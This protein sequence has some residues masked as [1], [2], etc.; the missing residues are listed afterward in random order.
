M[1]VAVALEHRFSRTPDGAVWTESFFARTFWERYL[2]VFDGVRIVARVKDVDRREDGWKRVDGNGVSIVPIPYYVGPVAYLRNRR[3]VREA[4]RRAV[5]PED[6]VILSRQL[7]N[8]QLRGIGAAPHPAI[9]SPSRLWPTPTASSLRAPSVLPCAGSCAG[10]SPCVFA[11]SAAMLRRLLRHTRTLQHSY[12]PG[13]HAFHTNYSSVELSSACFV[14][15]P[16]TEAPRAPFQLVFVGSL[17]VYYKAPDVLLNAIAACRQEGIDLRLDTVGDGRRRVE[18]EALAESLGIT[19]YVNF[20][21]LLPSGEAVRE[22]LDRADLFVLP[23]LQEGLPRAMIEAMARALPSI[24][25]TAGGIPELLPPED[26]VAPGDAAALAYKIREVV[27]N[28]GR[29]QAMSRRS[30]DT[31]ADYCED[32]LAPR[33]AKFYRALR[34]ATNQ[35]LAGKPAPGHSRLTTA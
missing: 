22:H 14:A 28:P 8:R 16:R 1:D 13:R 19:P 31:A 25:S 35:W 17:E 21:G 7:A 10:G 11:V 33:R 5:R 26:L 4:C 29:M 27:T 34:E 6:A 23:S 24:G 30:L 15:A 9:P 32:V 12:P 20:A 18:L 2:A 3:A